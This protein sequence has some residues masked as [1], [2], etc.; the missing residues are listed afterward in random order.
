[1]SWD[2]VL[3]LFLL[4]ENIYVKDAIQT[5]TKCL[6]LIGIIIATK[7]KACLQI[8]WPFISLYCYGS[9]I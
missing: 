5:I 1:M 3:K 9:P 6:E 2:P 7:G 8:K 4:K